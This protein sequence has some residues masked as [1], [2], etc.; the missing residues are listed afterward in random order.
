M[1]LKNNSKKIFLLILFLALISRLYYVFRCPYAVV[2][3]DTCSIWLM[4]KHAIEGDPPLFFYGQAY[5]WPLESFVTAVFFILFGIKAATLYLGV[6]TFYMLFLITTYFLVKELF[7][8]YAGIIAVLFFTFSSPELFIQSILPHGYHIEILL[9][10]NIILLLTLKICG[11]ISGPRRFILYSLLGAAAALGFWVHFIIAYY[12]LPVILFLLIKER[13]GRLVR[14]GFVSLAAAFLSA[15]PF[16]LFAIKT[17]F[18]TFKFPPIK[19]HDLGF[20]YY[21][22]AYFLKICNMLGLEGMSGRIAAV[23]YILSALYFIGSVIFNKRFKGG[24]IILFLGISVTAV[25][26]SYRSKM[27]AT[28]GYHYMM[29][30]LIFISISFVTLVRR[31]GYIGMGILIFTLLFNL[32]GINRMIGAR[33]VESRGKIEG[34]M[35]KV[36]FL[37]DNKIYRYIGDDRQSRMPVFFS[38]EKVIA[39]G[40][41]DGE[42]LVHED[43]VE[44]SDRVAFEGSGRNWEAVFNNICASYRSGHGFYFDFKPHPYKTRSIKPDRWTAQSRPGKFSPRYAFDRAYDTY[45]STGGDGKKT[46]MHF[47]VDLGSIYNVCRVSMFNINHIKNFTKDCRI[48]SSINGRDWEEVMY[49]E[50]GE[51]VFWSGPRIYFR[52]MYGRLEFF[53]KPVKTRFIRIIQIG[54]DELKPWEI[55]ELFVYEYLGEEDI[56]LRDYVKDAREITR[57]MDG[58]GIDFAYADFWL[59]A[60][61]KRF[62]NN[63]INALAP[64]NTYVPPRKY[65]SR[66]VELSASTAFVVEKKDSLE[67]EDALRELGMS[68]RKKEFN[69]FDCYY[70]SGLDP[71][72]TGT[73]PMMW[74]GISAI[75]IN[76]KDFSQRLFN[77][78]SEMERSGNLNDAVK[79]YSKAV[80]Y[81][82]NNFLAYL[83]LYRLNVNENIKQLIKKKF[84]PSV[85][86]PVIFKN[87][88]EF[89]GYE[90]RGTPRPGGLVKIDYFWK[91]PEKRDNRLSVFVYF[92]KDGK[93]VFQNDHR[94]LY[95]FPKKIEPLD[96]E[97]FRERLNLVIPPNAERG[98]YE[99]ILGL[100]EKDRNKRINIV[101]PRFKRKS[102]VVIGSLELL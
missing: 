13:F 95:Q 51:P 25:Y 39:S 58:D 100:W 12:F 9:F 99:I 44:A 47:T 37:L 19:T 71:A 48:E 76:S 21:L 63:K 10:G 61:I 17:R 78:G 38:R 5:L 56:S 6:I 72:Y 83:G 66:E 65:M 34:I 40:Y 3:S 33:A 102:K 89:L 88:V 45:W 90:L 14:Y 69:I 86:R 24:L 87:G 67:F 32:T 4:A 31:T 1:F 75:K 46:G 36:N 42:Y 20:F 82:S 43:A 16:W 96:G 57:F 80:D 79:Y 26:S 53:F 92:I 73:R 94:F 85:K 93:I 22:K 91:I 97:R 62:S 98:V 68:F 35:A 11:D 41:M 64:F 27:Y 52:L 70:F 59:S 55:N 101:D 8:S 7:D 29:P 60:K 30:I 74:L 28:G 84:I 15:L 49:Y 23:I 54:E 81:Y 77:K 2:D 50:E 18:M